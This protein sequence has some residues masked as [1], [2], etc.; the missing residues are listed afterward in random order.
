MDQ[1]PDLERDQQQP[2]RIG[3][4]KSSVFE[5]GDQRSKHFPRCYAGQFWPTMKM[6]AAKLSACFRAGSF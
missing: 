4:D 3:Q 5:V 1:H 6:W 2:K